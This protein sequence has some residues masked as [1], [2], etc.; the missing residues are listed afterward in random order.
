LDEV[1]KA[2]SDVL[3]LFLQIF[4]DG[5]LTDAK[6]RVAD[7]TNALFILTSNLGQTKT[8]PAIGFG[9]RTQ[10]SAAPSYDD[11]V[12]R[13]FRPELV[14]RL[15]AIIAFNALSDSDLRQI[16]KAM[17]DQLQE[18]LKAPGIELE[19]TTEA[20]DW[21]CSQE[22]DESLGARPLRRAV[23]QG[24]EN[25]IAA[26]LVRGELKEGDRVLLA[27]SAGRLTFTVRRKGGG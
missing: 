11:A 2:H 15:D 4:D 5:R 8:P 1:E 22:R 9:E 21:I 10:K 18:R 24:V 25:Q 14:N 16:A 27:A 6:G 13:A 12:R 7:A 23:E 3:N 19:V 26:M 17:L 20:V